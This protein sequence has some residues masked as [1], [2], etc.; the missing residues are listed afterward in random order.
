MIDTSRPEFR[1]ISGY[2]AFQPQFYQA[3]FTNVPNHK[4]EES[5]ERERSFLQ[6]WLHDIM[7]GVDLNNAIGRC[8][9]ELKQIENKRVQI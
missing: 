7:G 6:F 8:L 9:N 4:V 3:L 5:L 1:E 2:N